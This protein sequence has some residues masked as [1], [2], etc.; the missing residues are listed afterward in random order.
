[1]DVA[2]HCPNLQTF[3]GADYHDDSVLSALS[4]GCHSLQ[5]LRITGSSEGVCELA[6]RCA[7]L[8]RIELLSTNLD[9][10]CLIALVRSNPGLLIFRTCAVGATQNFLRE[11]AV[12]CRSL[13]SLRVS[14][15]YLMQASVYFLLETCKDL[16]NLQLTN[17]AFFPPE[18]KVARSANYTNMQRIHL[19]NVDIMIEELDELLCACPSLTH[20]ELWNCKEL[21][22]LESLSVGSYCPSLQV[23][24]IV[25]NAS[26]AG[27]KMLLDISQHCPRLRVLRIPDSPNATDTGLS[28][29]IKYCPLLSEVGIQGCGG[30]SVELKQ[31]IEQR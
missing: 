18:V 27:D 25:G 8:K 4:K 24:S 15:V 30:V 16:R 11:L 7:G 17:C 21:T 2:E 3:D 6:K 29:I 10:K 9:E 31:A 26:S 19:S 5:Q 22:D 14:D 23:L 28:A 13:V 1:V 20:L 12:S